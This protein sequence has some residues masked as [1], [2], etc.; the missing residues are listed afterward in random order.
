[1]ACHG[2]GVVSALTV[3]HVLGGDG[4]ATAAGVAVGHGVRPA[5]DVADVG[6]GPA[7]HHAAVLAM[8]ATK[9]RASVSW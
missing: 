1:M 6:Q 3:F 5:A 2:Q 9:A 8:A 4:V 7:G